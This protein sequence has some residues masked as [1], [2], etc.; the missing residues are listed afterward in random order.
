M[1]DEEGTESS[2]VPNAGH[3]VVRADKGIFVP[4]TNCRGK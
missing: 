1:R 4:P 3:V 2:L